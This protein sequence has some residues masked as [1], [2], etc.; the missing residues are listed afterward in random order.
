MPLA[1]QPE[2]L[3][4]PKSLPADAYVSLMNTTPTTHPYGTLITKISIHN[5]HATLTDI[6]ELYFTVNSDTPPYESYNRFLRRTIKPGE[7]FEW[8][9]PGAVSGDFVFGARSVGGGYCTIWV[10]GMSLGSST[11]S[12]GEAYPIQIHRGY[13]PTD[14][15]IR[16]I[17]PNTPYAQVRGITMHNFATSTVATIVFNIYPND[18]T[19]PTSNNQVM[20]K[21]IQPGETITWEDVAFMD[22]E[23]IITA[24]MLTG[25]NLVSVHAWGVRTP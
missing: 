12:I 13:M 21:V 17:V 23:N 18:G 20:T 11:P 14:N 10:L 22:G 8:T 7:V 9:M 25:G 4:Y 6:I 16:T 5:T 24:R 3:V 19:E 15:V 2:M 1:P